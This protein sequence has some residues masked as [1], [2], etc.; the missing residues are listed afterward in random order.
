MAKESAVLKSIKDDC[1]AIGLNLDS[2][3]LKRIYY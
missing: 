2:P 1:T 3:M